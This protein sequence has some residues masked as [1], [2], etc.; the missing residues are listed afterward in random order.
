M[1]VRWSWRVRVGLI[2]VLLLAVLLSSRVLLGR[3]AT[4][5]VVRVAAAQR[6]DLMTAVT[7]TG[8]VQSGRTVDIKYDGQDFVDR[9]FVREGQTVHR[10]QALA[11]MDTQLLSHTRD[12]ASQLVA[13]D[14]AN[15][16]LAEATLRRNETLAASQLVAPPPRANRRMC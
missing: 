12:Q 6:G 2:A 16:A 14:D 13:R 8:S 7:A 4:P 10:G 15:L 1:R 11:R 5:V 9:L 3:D